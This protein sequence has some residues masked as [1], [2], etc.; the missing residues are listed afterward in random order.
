MVAQSAKI[1]QSGHTTYKLLHI[2]FNILIGNCMSFNQKMRSGQ[3][4]WLSWQSSHFQYQRSEVRIQTPA[5]FYRAFIFYCQLYL[6]YW[7]DENKMRPGMAHFSR[8][9]YHCTYGWTPV[10]YECRRFGQIVCCQR[11][12]K[13]AQSAKNRQIWSRWYRTNLLNPN[14]VNWRPDVQRCFPLQSKL[15]LLEL[16][17]VQWFS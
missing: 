17:Q 15:I 13:V 5:N 16:I 14:R 9:H 7:K 12:Q 10:A 8:F 1:A 4:L 11:I 2:I 3:W 6:L